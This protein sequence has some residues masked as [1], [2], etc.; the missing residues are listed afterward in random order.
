MDNKKKIAILHFGN[1]LNDGRVLRSIE[2]LSKIYDLD[3]YS[4]EKDALNTKNKRFISNFIFT[5]NTLGKAKHLSFA[6]Q[7]FLKLLFK[8]YDAIYFH[9]FLTLLA[10]S[11]ILRLKK[12]HIIY[13]AHE[14][15]IEDSEDSNFSTY[16]KLWRNLERTLINKFTLIITANEERAEIMRKFYKTDLNI[17]VVRNLCEVSL[18]NGITNN[19]ATKPF[20]IVYQGAINSDRGLDWL[21]HFFSQL[22]N[23]DIQLVLVGDGSD[24]VRLEALSDKLNI[25]NKVNFLG[26]ISRVELYQELL[27][28][29]LGVISY[30]FKGLNV[31]YCAPNKI[32]EYTQMG[33]PVISTP[34]K[35]VYNE[36]EHNEIGFCVTHNEIE[37]LKFNESVK[38]FEQ[39]RYNYSTLLKNAEIFSKINSWEAESNSFINKVKE[40]LN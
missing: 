1:V 32:Y 33:I 5:N 9:D 24:R 27:S 3:I 19:K 7:V 8:K 21:F 18:K 20:K 4:L 15:I 29:H 37:S 30:N 40:V 39:I 34:Q 6:I 12:T 23:E 38:R 36:I 26:K 14:L 10:A 35:S 25:K 17:H 13:D 22:N 28:C 16:G 11:L 2:S 31:K